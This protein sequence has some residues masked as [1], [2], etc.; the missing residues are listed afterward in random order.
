MYVIIYVYFSRVQS[1]YAYH[2]F[3]SVFVVGQP[4]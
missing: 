4:S 1:K 3:I 2:M